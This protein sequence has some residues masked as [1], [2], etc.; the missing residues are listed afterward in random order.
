M[1]FKF[2]QWP[3]Q[4]AVNATRVS[5]SLFCKRMCQVK[6]ETW[7]GNKTRTRTTSS[8]VWASRMCVAGGGGGLIFD[9]TP[10]FSVM[11]R[12]TVREED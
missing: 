10:D 7:N 1:G 12:K 11:L 2:L 8:N 6:R 3:H 5:W 9:L 4:G